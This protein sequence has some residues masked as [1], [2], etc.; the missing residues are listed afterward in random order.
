MYKEKIDKRLEF[1]FHV[2]PKHQLSQTW[3]SKR[4]QKKHKKVVNLK[5]KK[6]RLEDFLTLKK[7]YSILLHK[8]EY[9]S[10][11]QEDKL[12]LKML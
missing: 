6:L 9:L 2:I 10:N 8:S 11:L 4:F 5:Q 7:Q 1:F 12:E 3:G